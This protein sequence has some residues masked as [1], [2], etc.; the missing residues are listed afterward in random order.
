ME[1]ILGAVTC[2][3]FFNFAGQPIDDYV[4][5]KIDYAVDRAIEKTFK[6]VK[7]EL[8]FGKNL[9]DKNYNFFWGK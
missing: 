5:R 8:D 7:D 3:L 9:R 1:F 2:L 6:K 4:D